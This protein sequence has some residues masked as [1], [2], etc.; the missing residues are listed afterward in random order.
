[1]L[2]LGGSTE[3]LCE[4]ITRREWL[5][6]GGL[7]ALGLMLPE[8]HAQLA[9]GGTGQS[10]GF[11]R[12]GARSCIVVFLFGNPAHNQDIWDLKPSAPSEIRGEFRPIASSVPGIL[13]G[14]HVPRI[15][16][17]AHRLALV[18]SV[19]HPD[20]THTVAM[21]YMLTGVRH[22][23][24]STNPQYQPDDFPTFGAV[25]QR[26][27]SGRGALPAGISLNAPANQVSANNHI[28]PGFFAGFLGSAYDPL[29]VSQ[30][31]GRGDFQP[32]PVAEG[33]AGQRLLQR[34][35]LLAEVDRQQQAL[36]QLAGMRNLDAHYARA[37]DLVTSP[38]ARRAPGLAAE[39]EAIGC[40]SAMGRRHSVRAC[41]SPGDSSRQAFRW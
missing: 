36:A 30:D 32:L 9:P 7:S 38:A 21:H 13:L 28:F 33:E 23:R 15:A 1:M 20:N 4:G 6:A 31:P 17:Q 10:R 26:L 14:E 25:V 11:V 3:R 41:C 5:R 22:S 27:R 40:G 19:S 34:R 2:A 37:F 12:P 24:P 35:P 18:R 39:S 8:L 16:R 29:F